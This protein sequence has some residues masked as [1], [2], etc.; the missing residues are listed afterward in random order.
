M[1]ALWTT[2]SHGKA[3][4]IPGDHRETPDA[5]AKQFCYGSLVS[6]LDLSPSL[7]PRTC[8]RLTPRWTS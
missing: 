2:G 6:N 5:W 1:L 8:R 4:R 3:G 7:R